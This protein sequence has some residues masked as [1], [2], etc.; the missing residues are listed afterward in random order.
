[1]EISLYSNSSVRIRGA[2]ERDVV[3]TRDEL[4]QAHRLLNS[5]TVK[6]LAKLEEE[7]GLIITVEMN[8]GKENFKISHP[9]KSF[10]DYSSLGQVASI[11]ELTAWIKGYTKRSEI[12][13]GQS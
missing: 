1:M 13:K 4:L 11:E 8:N 9:K 5:P 3:F 7:S 10:P 12:I 6:T 2:S